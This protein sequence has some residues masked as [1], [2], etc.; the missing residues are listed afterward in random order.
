MRLRVSEQL[1]ML[2]H[3]MGRKGEKGLGYWWR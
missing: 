2:S 1:G 3:E